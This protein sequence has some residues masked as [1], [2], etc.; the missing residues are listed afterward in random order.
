MKRWASPVC[1]I[2]LGLLF[3]G[4]AQFYFLRGVERLREG[5]RESHEHL[6]SSISKL[7]SSDEQGRATKLVDSC[8][9]Q[10]MTSLHMAEINLRLVELAGA[11][12]AA[13]GI[14]YLLTL[15]KLGSE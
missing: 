8:T 13:L 5:T 6:L 7:Q 10:L 14:D 3:L 15:R 4:V 11:L 9:E 2:A 1:A 12:L